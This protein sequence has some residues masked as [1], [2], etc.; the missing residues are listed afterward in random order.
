[1]FLTSWCAPAVWP[2]SPS[3]AKTRTEPAPA[4]LSATASPAAMGAPWPD[5]PVFALKK[6]VLPSIS[7]WPGRPPFWRSVRRSSGSSVKCRPSGCA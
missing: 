2:P 1:V 4:C 7:A 5:G 3:I 6:S